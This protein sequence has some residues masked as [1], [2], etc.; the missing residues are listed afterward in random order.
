MKSLFKYWLPVI[1]WAVFIFLGSTDLM[2]AE[3]T[4]RFLVPFL[5]WLNPDITL[6]AIAKIHFVIRKLGHVTEYAI[7]VALLWR[8]LRTRWGTQRSAA[9]A[10][11]LSVGYAFS[12]EFHQSFISTRTA[13]F[14]DVAID[15]VGVIVGL[16]IYWLMA[17]RGWIDNRPAKF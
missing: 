11:V 3:H 2:S 17:R 14:Y 9:I 15:G 16:L 12:D 8:A 10:F 13:S 1:A 4:S 5:H 7:L 6:A